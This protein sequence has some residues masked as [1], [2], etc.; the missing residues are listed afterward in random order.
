MKGDQSCVVEEEGEEGDEMTSTRGGIS[1]GDVTEGDV[2]V[3][4]D[5]L[6]KMLEEED[7]AA[8]DAIL[9]ERRKTCVS[10]E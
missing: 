7:R 5:E 3:W 9:R 4:D 2:T 1:E 6:M 8:W 10:E